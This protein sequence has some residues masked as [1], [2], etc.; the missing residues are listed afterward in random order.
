MARRDKGSGS[1]YKRASDGMWVAS[2]TLPDGPDGRRRRKVIA[3]KAKGDAI[4]ELRKLRAE[5]DKAGD[6]QTNMPTVEVYV[7]ESIQQRA[8]LGLLRPRTVDSHSKV[9]ERYIYPSIGRIRIDRLTPAHVRK[10]HSFVVDGGRSTTTALQAHNVLSGALKNAVRDGLVTRNAAANTDKPKPAHYSAQVLTAP[11]AV[12]LLRHV[13]GDPMESARWSLALLAGLRQGEALGLTHQHVDLERNVLAIDWQ[14]QQLDE[15][16]GPTIRSRHIGGRV[17]LLPVKSER[18][19]RLVPMVPMLRDAMERR[20]AQ[21]SED[22][23][24]FVVTAPK[25]GPRDASADG[26]A[27][28]RLLKEAGLPVIRLHDA[29]HTTGTLLRAAGIEPRLI[30]V[31][32][33]H[34]SNAMTEHYSHIAEGESVAAMEKFAMLIEGAR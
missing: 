19:V 9:A 28:R 10:M 31:I 13:H 7:R 18:S 23:W 20:L 14:L 17:W 2:V 24:G 1:I 8:R 16:P 3:R 29:R 32:L 4:A 30:Q 21:M 27:W 12:T 33:G 25:G 5:L 22:P 26:K 6:I 15:P 11:Q 34:N